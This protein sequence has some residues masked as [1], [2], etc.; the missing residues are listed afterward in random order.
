MGGG[1]LQVCQ[2]GVCK[3]KAR[4][5]GENKAPWKL[6]RG[7][8][9]SAYTLRVNDFWASAPPKGE[10]TSLRR[11]SCQ[12]RSLAKNRLPKQAAPQGQT[13]GALELTL[14]CSLGPSYLWVSGTWLCVPPNRTVPL[15]G[16]SE[17]C[18]PGTL[19]LQSNA[20]NGQEGPHVTGRGPTQRQALS[21]LPRAY[22]FLTHG[23]EGTLR[24]TC[25]P[26]QTE[27][28]PQALRSS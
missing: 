4:G 3:E 22:A 5:A 2:Q 19:T 28:E 6:F 27:A 8:A 10:M 23:R 25:P 16:V 11:G 12:P 1:G 21:E 24:S 9:L 18:L 26:D 17:K 15:A 20:E 7:S 14:G 13:E